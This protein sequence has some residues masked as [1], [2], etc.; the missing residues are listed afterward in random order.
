MDE[1]PIGVARDPPPQI[2]EPDEQTNIPS[3]AGITERQQALRL[4]GSLPQQGAGVGVA[5][6]HTVERYHVD[7]RDRVCDAH[8]V[9]LQEA[10]PISAETLLEFPP[11]HLLVSWR[12]L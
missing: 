3:C 9:A 6:H 4:R 12:G 7:R 8:E 2:L 5:A 11:C 10:G 1:A